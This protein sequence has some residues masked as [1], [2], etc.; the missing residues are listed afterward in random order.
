M[1]STGC[2]TRLA[3]HTTQQL[4]LCGAK[5]RAKV[6][7]RG[8]PQLLLQLVLAALELGLQIGDPLRQL[9][10]Q[11]LHRVELLDHACLCLL[12]RLDV[13]GEL[14]EFLVQQLLGLDF[15][16]AGKAVLLRQCSGC[17][18]V[19]KRPALSTEAWEFVGQ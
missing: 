6:D 10:H 11:V 12:H 2:R 4:P 18:G 9:H 15:A 8:L 16:G 19:G 7:H 3:K 5:L 14:L 1:A 17:G 13:L